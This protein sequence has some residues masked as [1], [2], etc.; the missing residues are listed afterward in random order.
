MQEEAVEAIVKAQSLDF[1]EVVVVYVSQDGKVS[2]K[3]LSDYLNKL[4]RKCIACK[5]KQINNS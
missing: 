5:D 4:R 1:V 2:P 3:D